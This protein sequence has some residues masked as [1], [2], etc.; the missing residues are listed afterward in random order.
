M[1]DALLD[2]LSSIGEEVVDAEEESFL[3][4]SRSTPSNNLGFLDSR[5]TTIDLTI[6]SHDYTIHQSPTLLSSTRD[7]GTTGAVLWKITPLFAS[8][9]SSVSSNP[10]WR[11][12]QMLKGGEAAVIELGCG[13]SG[14]VALTL[15][16]LVRKYVA[17]DQEYVRRFFRQNIDENRHITAAAASSKKG[18][19]KK[20]RAAATGGGG[21]KRGK[22]TPN[23]SN[24]EF[25]PLDWEID[26]PRNETLHAD[27]TTDEA[28]FD[29]VVS[30]DCIYNEALIPSFVRTCADICLLRSA[31]NKPSNEGEEKK[32]PTIAIIAQQQRSP[33]VFEAW[34]KETLRHFRVWRVEKFDVSPSSA[35]AGEGGGGSSGLGDGSGY[36]VHVLVLRD[37]L[38][39]S[40]SS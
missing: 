4:F 26:V 35:S 32:N 12:G 20:A 39:T 9:I 27:D 11:S 28:G 22:D 31:V 30:C 23:S 18:S 33:D 17:T 5:A 19:S 25:I 15:A 6:N 16:P 3:L 34:L 24:I 29:L 14:L 7:G 38:P 40:S 37:D 2:F 8:W 36:M 10:F 21:T 1:S 13:I